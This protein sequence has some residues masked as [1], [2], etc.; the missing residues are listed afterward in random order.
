MLVWGGENFELSFKIWQCGGSIEWVPCSRVGHVYRGF[1]PY[2]FGKLAEKKKGPL[3][4]I[5]Y[6]RVI[7]VWF[8]EIHKEYFYT[9]EPL[10]RF[11][12]MG[13][14]TE[15]LELK[16]KLNCKS[17]QWYMENVAYD[18]FDKY[19]Q[20]PENL[21]W[22]EF[23]NL[24]SSKCLD[25]MGRQPPSMMGVN[26]CHKMGNNQLIRLNAAGQL[27][28]GERCVEADNQGVK[29]AF[30]RL[31][32]VDGPWLYH[33]DTSL[34]EHRTQKKCMAVHPQSHHLSLNP[35]DVNNAYQQ[36]KFKELKPNY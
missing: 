29:L 35:C 12:D 5:N 13:D 24:A 28:V 27:G 17:F 6:K 21:H 15:Q 33:E 1:M 2:N 22:G 36:W 11:L 31:G 34:I 23:R 20:L 14:I 3:I 30:C 7:E 18:V 16:K 4:T 32:T 9:R 25:A 8:D 26:Y 19:P 10:A